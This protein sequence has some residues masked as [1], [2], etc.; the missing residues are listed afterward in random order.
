MMDL[1]RYVQFLPVLLASA[2]SL[3]FA[4]IYYLRA[5]RA[6]AGNRG[7]LEWIREYGR[8]GFHFSREALT[9]HSFDPLG[10]FGVGV[11][12]LVSALG[13][14]LLLSKLRTG[15][16]LTGFFSLY[17]LCSVVL[18]VAS[19]LAMWVLLQ[20]L[21]DDGMISACGAVLFA[22]TLGGRN[23][24]ALLAISLLF[25]VRWF[26]TAPE[27][28]LFPR[29]LLYY[30]ACVF[31][32]LAVVT[33]PGLLWLAFFYALLHMGRCIRRFACNRR[34]GQLALALILA[35]AGW[36]L[37][38]VLLVFAQYALTYIFVGSLPGFAP[39][40]DA[41]YRYAA[42][43]GRWMLRSLLHRPMRSYA[44]PAMINAPVFFVGLAGLVMALVCAVRR[45][46][47]HCLLALCVTGALALCWALTG[48]Y[49]LTPGLILA[50][51]CLWQ[52][53]TA[54]GKKAPVVLFTVLGVGYSIVFCLAAAFLPLSA[55]LVSRLA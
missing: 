10:G 27:E 20:H 33:E 37:A 50:I 4:L 49:A 16:W 39:F 1:Q 34:G 6:V 15:A 13:Y 42:A 30:A 35:L 48:S 46:E 53:F 2:G 55:D 29:E 19:A 22:A 18:A 32:I 5:S 25:L 52:V 7:G 44:L 21:F 51:A 28:A 17:T 8:P 12:A 43:I 26:L 3:V 54:S 24:T 36:A 41:F 40:T 23:T 14:A 47:P 9:C 45:H 11:F 38:A 31:L